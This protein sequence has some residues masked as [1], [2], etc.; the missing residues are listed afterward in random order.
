M[1]SVLLWNHVLRVKSI[2]VIITSGIF[3]HFYYSNYPFYLQVDCQGTWTTWTDCMKGNRKID[4]GSGTRTRHWSIT[5]EAQNGGKPC[6]NKG[7]E[8][9][10]CSKE[11]AC[12]DGERFFWNTN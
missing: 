5:Q 6:S 4:C 1:R 11:K 7:V 3:T 2:G 10:K 12:L 9:K 8:S